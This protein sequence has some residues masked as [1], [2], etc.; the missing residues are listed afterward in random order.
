MTDETK[1]KLQAQAKKVNRSMTS[2]I[3]E[4]IE[5]DA[6]MIAVPT[7]GIIKDGKVFFG[8]VR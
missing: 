1:E 5:R 3:V 4:L 6:Q 7:V 8:E 2:Y